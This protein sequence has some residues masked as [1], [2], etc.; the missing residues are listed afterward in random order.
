MID[1]GTL[2][3]QRGVALNADDRVRREA[4]QRLM[5]AG[6]LEFLSFARAVVRS[7]VV[8]PLSR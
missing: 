2:A 8:R 3:I 1:A 5:C 4:I 6:I 7:T